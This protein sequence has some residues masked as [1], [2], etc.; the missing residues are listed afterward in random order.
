MADLDEFC[1]Q[2]EGEPNAEVPHLEP[3]EDAVEAVVAGPIPSVQPG[4]GGGDEYQ[5]ED[6][7]A[8]WNAHRPEGQEG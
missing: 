3:V 5:R 8:R 2:A 4:K 6:P 7:H 1:E